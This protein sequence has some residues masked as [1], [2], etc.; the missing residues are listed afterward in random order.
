MYG[1]HIL[2]HNQ[3]TNQALLDRKN[4]G[5]L[6]TKAN[7]CN[8]AKA[9]LEQT[10]SFWKLL[11]ADFCKPIYQPLLNETIGESAICTI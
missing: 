3:P 11:E 1:K 5:S 7:F 6:Q 8:P 9:L 4:F 2:F 10:N